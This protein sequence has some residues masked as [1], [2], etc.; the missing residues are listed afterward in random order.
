MVEHGVEERYRIIERSD[1]LWQKSMVF[2]T[3][4]KQVAEFMIEHTMQ[5]ILQTIFQSLSEMVFL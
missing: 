5:K 2:L 1:L 4:L 3:Q